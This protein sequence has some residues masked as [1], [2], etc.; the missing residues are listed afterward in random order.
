[1]TSSTRRRWRPWT[2]RGRFSAALPPA[3]LDALLDPAAYT[4]HAG[5]FVDCV[6]ASARSMLR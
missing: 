6:V 1:M 3:E 2:A 4:G 5:V